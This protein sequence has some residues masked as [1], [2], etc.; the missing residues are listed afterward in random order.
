MMQTASNALSKKS[1]IIAKDYL[2]HSLS[3]LSCMKSTLGLTHIRDENKSVNE[4]PKVW[5]N[6]PLRAH[7][8]D[9]LCKKNKCVHD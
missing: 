7:Y 5:V 6:K 9:S 3:Y 1:Y 2:Q 4:K 8:L